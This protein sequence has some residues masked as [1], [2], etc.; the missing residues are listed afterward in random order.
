MVKRLY[1]DGL[2]QRLGEQPNKIIILYGARQVGKTTLAKT[3]LQALPGRHLFINA[4]DTDYTDVLSS[5]SLRRLQTIVGGYDLLLLDEAHRVP[6]I[7]LSLKI[8]HDSMPDLRIIATGS[9][10]FDLAN[11]TQEPLT[12]RHWTYTLYPLALCELA[13]DMSPFE[14]DQQL[15]SFLVFGGYPQAWLMPN[16][17][18]KMEYLRGL[19]ASYLYKDIL[20]LSPIKYAQKLRDLVKLLAYQIGSEVSINELSN[21]LQ[22]SSETVMHYIDLLEKAFVIFRLHGYNRNLRKEVT[23][24]AKIYFWDLGVRNAVIE[25]FNPLHLRNDSGA[26]WENFLLAERQKTLAYTRRN[27]NR[28]FWRTYTGAELDYVEETGGQLY[29]YEFKFSKKTAK[30]PQTWSTEYPGSRFEVV[31]RD[32]YLSFLM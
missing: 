32:N 1:E 30:A 28:Y 29:G 6:D 27:A 18:D 7:G 5:R 24:H 10:S 21:R 20:D 22:I 11:K 23:R 16:N 25:N 17:A 15:E 8:L 4:E 13:A 2:V 9:S 19:T 14:L 3:V 12:G 31:N 26:L